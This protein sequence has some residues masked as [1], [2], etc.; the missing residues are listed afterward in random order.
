MTRFA[1]LWPHSVAENIKSLSLLTQ[2]SGAS[3]L[4]FCQLCKGQVSYLQKMCQTFVVVVILL[5]CLFIILCLLHML[6]Y[7]CL[8]NYLT[9][10]QLQQLI[11]K[12]DNTMIDC[13]FKELMLLL[14]QIFDLEYLCGEKE[15]T[16]KFGTHSFV[17]CVIVLFYFRYSFMKYNKGNTQLKDIQQKMKYN[18]NTFQKMR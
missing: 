1:Y 9:F 8:L 13:Q 14:K 16:L 17:I 10:L 6:K 12:N 15:Q 11:Q 3:S 4:T 5:T 18:K 2:S 7:V